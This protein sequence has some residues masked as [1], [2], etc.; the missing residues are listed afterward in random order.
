MSRGL[1]EEE[2]LLI[3]DINGD[4]VITN[5]DLQALQNILISGGGYQNR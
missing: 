2:L 5:A 4:G 3:A 1:T